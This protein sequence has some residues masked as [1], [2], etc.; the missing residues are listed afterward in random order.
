MNYISQSLKIQIFIDKNDISSSD[1]VKLYETTVDPSAPVFLANLSARETSDD[2]SFGDSYLFEF[3]KQVNSNKTYSFEWRI[4]D[5]LG[6][7]SEVVGSSSK[8]VNLTPVTPTV[9]AFESLVFGEIENNIGC[10]YQLKMDENEDSNDVYDSI[11]NLVAT[12]WDT[13]EN[14]QSGTGYF[15]FNGSTDRINTNQNFNDIFSSDF[16]VNFWAKVLDGNPTEPYDKTF[17]YV[18]SSGGSFCYFYY[19]IDGRME[20]VYTSDYNSTGTHTIPT[21]VVLN[22]GENDWKMFTLTVSQVTESTCDLSIYINGILLHTTSGFDATMSLW[23][24]N[25]NYLTIGGNG[26]AN[27]RFYGAMDN[28]CLYNKVL[29]SSDIEFLY[30]SGTVNENLNN[31]TSEYYT[32]YHE[33]DG[34][35]STQTLDG[36]FS[37][38]ETT[39]SIPNY[40]SEDGNYIYYRTQT[41]SYTTSAES[42]NLYIS[43]DNGIVHEY[44][45]TDVTNL[46]AFQQADGKIKLNWRYSSNSSDSTD[47]FNIYYMLNPSTG[48]ELLDTV[49]YNSY[50][51][52]YQYI[53]DA[54]DHGTEITFKVFPVVV[55]GS[56]EY[57]RE[58][59]LEAS[60]TADSQAPNITTYYSTIN[61]I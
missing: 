24:S 30:N 1:I 11:N 23:N 39:F 55:S 34:S 26:N 58:N 13:T 32:I 57:E 20:V 19:M 15:N 21:P 25:N 41:D 4:A 52:M 10:V 40:P 35:P 48:F 45:L 33:L 56:L 28:F 6:N 5:K 31:Y 17:F 37:T 38:A 14:M 8:E 43:V 9:L 53:T 61:L 50:I 7:E 29:S 47:K 54:F 18:G 44:P 49:D 42:G 12:S 60:A 3:Y 2:P 51:Q 59:N 16:S 27:Y 22:D 46:Y 36:Y